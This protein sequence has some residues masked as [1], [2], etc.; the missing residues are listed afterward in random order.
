MGLTVCLVFFP[1]SDVLRLF[2][3]ASNGIPIIDHLFRKGPYA[4][5]TRLCLVTWL[6]QP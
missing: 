3:K 4:I 6:V 5:L 1:A 2:K